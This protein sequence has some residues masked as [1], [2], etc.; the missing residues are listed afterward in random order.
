MNIA[1]YQV[2]MM[3]HTGTFLVSWLHFI[4]EYFHKENIS[5]VFFYVQPNCCAPEASVKTSAIFGCY[6]KYC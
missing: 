1:C 3:E 6:T 2:A 4:S 5:A